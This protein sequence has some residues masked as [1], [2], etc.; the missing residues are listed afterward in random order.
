MLRIFILS[1]RITIRSVV[2]QVTLD[3]SRTRGFDIELY[4]YHDRRE[5]LELTG[6]APEVTDMLQSRRRLGKPIDIKG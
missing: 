4:R 3:D 1:V 6:L 5:H 2:R